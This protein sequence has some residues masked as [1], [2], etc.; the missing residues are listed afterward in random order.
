M[1][2]YVPNDE[3]ERILERYGG[4][5]YAADDWQLVQTHL[6][7]GDG[8]EELWRPGADSGPEGAEELAE[9]LDRAIAHHALGDLPP[10]PAYLN[11]RFEQV[12]DGGVL[13]R[14][15]LRFPQVGEVTLRRTFTLDWIPLTA[16]DVRALLPPPG[17]DGPHHVPDAL[18]RR[19]WLTL[20]PPRDQ[21]Q[22]PEP[23]AR[24]LV[25]DA[26]LRT[27]VVSSE[28]ATTTVAV[29]GALRLRRPWWWGPV[30]DGSGTWSEV[31]AAEARL[32]GVIT[33]VEGEVGDVRL[34]L[35]DGW[36]QPPSGPK[37]AM[38]GIIRRELPRAGHGAGV[39]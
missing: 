33:L 23:L 8:L 18:A 36:F 32:R 14:T 30:G 20:R 35:H 13:L 12:G 16:D 7:V 29:A 22:D 31:V 24:R 3:A 39:P 38:E 37:V 25:R 34:H 1:P 2:L 19:I 21:A 27:R 5:P 28:G 4:A 26:V 6:I 17:S 9:A 15:V 10:L 11:D